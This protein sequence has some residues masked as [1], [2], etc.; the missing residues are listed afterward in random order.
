MVI[1]MMMVLS[2]TAQKLYD[3]PLGVQTYTFRNHF[4]KGVESTIELIKDLG[5][6]EIETSGANGISNQDFKKLC[7]AR[8]ISIPSTGADFGELEKDP[9]IVI[10]RAKS[11]GATFVMCAW[12]PHKS[13]Q[14]SLA[15]AE[16]A[17]Q[18]FNA[19][20]KMLKEKGLTLCYH[21]HGYEF[22]KYQEGS[23]LDYMIKTQI[24]NM[25]LLKWTCFGPCMVGV[26][27]CL[28][29]Y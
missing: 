22:Q 24:P 10:E 17:I 14:F 13:S 1:A 20:G 4:P 12:I 16:H 23:L 3:Y 18:V 11:F 28:L 19:A 8:G 21:D 15:D 25:F 27:I 2:S 26:L 29:H 5:F 7:D 6:T 9:Q